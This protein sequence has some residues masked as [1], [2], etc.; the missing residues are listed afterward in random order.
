M[1]AYA[2]IGARSTPGDILEIMRLSA[3]TLSAKYTCN[4]GAAKGA[5][6][7]FA[8]G[9][10]QGGGTVQLFLPWSSYENTWR[11]SLHGRVD[12]H[13]LQYNDREA[14]D[15]VYKFHPAA[16]KLK[17]TVIKLH[18]RNFCILRQVDFVICWTPNGDIIGGTGQALRIAIHNGIKIYN[19]GN[20]ETLAA[21]KQSLGI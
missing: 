9:A 16:A 5:D 12:T 15:S 11:N 14:F 6:Q 21:F 17:Q 13:V 7:A 10:L 2:G 3:K 1:V 19:L 20:P 18:A 8:E 4:T